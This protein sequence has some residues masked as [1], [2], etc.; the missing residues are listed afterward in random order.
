[1]CPDLVCGLNVTLRIKA[2][3]VMRTRSG[4]AIY[5]NLKTMVGR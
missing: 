1:M 5:F 3:Q 4:Q 2:D